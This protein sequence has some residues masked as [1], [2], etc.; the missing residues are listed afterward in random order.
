MRR[1]KAA[2]LSDRAVCWFLRTIAV[3]VLL[4]VAISL[5]LAT[6]DSA[7]QQSAFV[8]FALGSFLAFL[9]QAFADL[10]EAFSYLGL[11]NGII[12]LYS[13]VWLPA[14]SFVILS[15]L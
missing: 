14:V 12:Y 7:A 15:R 11:L 3:T 9:A 4:L 6:S 5:G 13:L 10:S 8:L 1:N 2:K